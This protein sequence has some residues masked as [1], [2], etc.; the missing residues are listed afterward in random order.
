M[1]TD[2]A[3]PVLISNPLLDYD[4]HNW[5]GNHIWLHKQ[6]WFLWQI[7]VFFKLFG[8]NEFVLRLPTAIMMTLMILII[9]KIGKLVSNTEIAWYGAFIY[10]FSYYFIN[11]IS[12]STFTDHN[13]SAFIFY[14]SLSIWSYLEY[15]HSK[16]KR[17]LILI[18]IFSG[19]AILNKWLVGFLVYSGWILNVFLGYSKNERSDELRKL[20]FSLAWTLIVALPWQLF[21]WFSYPLEGRYEFNGQHF[22]QAVEG[23]NEDQWY[24]FQLFG[25][26]YGGVIAILIILPGLICFFKSIRKKRYQ[27]P[28]VTYLIVTYLFFTLAA[29]KMPMFCT[30]VSPV[31]FLGLGAIS[32]KGVQKLREYIP[33]GISFWI[34]VLLL[35]CL[36]FAMLDINQI[37]VQ[38]SDK[39]TYWKLKK[40]DAII[41]RQVSHKLPSD[42]WVVF[43]CGEHNTVMVM[44]YSGATAYGHYPDSVQYGMLKSKGIG[45]ATFSD[46]H[47]PIYLKLDP[48]VI[49]IYLK[50]LSY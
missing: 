21:V 45:M 38:H 50:P 32:D 16:R 36:A 12:G 8:V 35:G 37:D 1:L 11:F 7:A 40:I 23:H 13:D 9:Y 30:I 48:S 47:I 15:I 29:T 44:F 3:K 28:L 5:K 33:A 6:P 31:L 10:T 20:A 22:F 19:I 39:N 25:E 34:I 43:N 2:P 49:K 26:Q 42:D 41:D 17:W 18:G 14:V 24:H 27:I 4:F 46:E